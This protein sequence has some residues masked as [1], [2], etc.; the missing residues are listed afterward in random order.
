MRDKNRID[1]TIKDIA[2]HLGLSHS[3][4]SRALRDVSSI[5]L[6]TRARVKEAAA[7]MGYIPNAGARML[8]QTQSDLIGV[9]F[10]DI[11][12]DFYSATMT[13][14]ASAF[15]EHSYKLVLATSED[16]PATELKHIQSLREARVAGVIIA[17]TAGMARA[18]QDLLSSIP[19]IQL[20]RQ[21]P[22]LH[23]AV[24]K[25]DE[26]EGIAMGVRHLVDRGH[27]RIGLIAG[28]GALSTGREREDG[29]IDALAS[30]G[31]EHDPALI[32]QGSP[33]PGFGHEA[34]AALL[35]LAAPPSAV[36]MASPQLTLGALAAIQERK[37]QV[38]SQLAIVGY[39]DP[40]WFRLW[41]AT[42][43]TSIRLPIQD[44]AAT[45]ASILLRKLKQNGS[46]PDEEDNAGADIVKFRPRL[47]V[48]GTT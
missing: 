38:P 46:A 28:F 44:M 2:E 9:I 47:L 19:T 7:A 42:G 18:S 10:P 3:T 21:H 6:E 5:R 26:R 13:T 36:V 34:M 1:I 41:G 27:R 25:V 48:R 29:Y 30:A 45:A 40:D 11:Q 37:I 35:D 14:L 24:V 8:R 43:I 32:W 22:R 17:P 31:I 23:T 12:N 16:S 4:V 39:H 20:L 15:L 33:R